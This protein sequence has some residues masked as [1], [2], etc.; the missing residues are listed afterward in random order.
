MVLYETIFIAPADWPTQ[1][2]DEFLEKIK[3][4]VE[5]AGGKLT[6]VDKWGRRRLAYP[7]KRHRE[8]FYV[9]FMFEAPGPFLAELDKFFLVSEEIIRQV[10]CKALKSKPASPT[11][12]FPSMLASPALPAAGTPTVSGAVPAAVAAPSAVPGDAPVVAPIQE[13]PTH[14]PAPTTPA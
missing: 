12:V 5:K 10:T 13:V 7:I 3:G 8:G 1:R 4:L 2:L 14:E 11:M 9:F 6:H